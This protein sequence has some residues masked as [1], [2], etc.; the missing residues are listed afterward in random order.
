VHEPTAI[1]LVPV[2]A[3]A[4]ADDLITAHATAPL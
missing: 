1:E 4:P 3:G 2:D